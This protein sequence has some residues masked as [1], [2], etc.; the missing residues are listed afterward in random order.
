MKN[1]PSSP[2][3]L[4]RRQF[5]GTLT[6]GAVT[7]AAA[8]RAMAQSAEPRKLGVALVGLGSYATGQLAPALKLTKNCY[9]AGV[10]TGDPQGKGKKWAAERGF[11]EKNIYTYDTMHQIADNKDIDIVYVVTPNSMHADQVII[12]AKA[13][14][15]VISEKPFTTNVPDAL[16]AMAACKA[17]KVKLSIGYR[18]HFDPTVQEY[19]RMAKAKEFGGSVKMDGEFSFVA[20]SQEW[21]QKKQY[22]GGGPLMDLG[23]Y[24]MQAS[25]MGAGGVPPVAVTAKFDPTTKPQIFQDVEEGL[26]WT[27]EFPGGEVATCAASYNASANRFRIE[28]DK[29]WLDFKGMVTG[30]DGTQREAGNAFMYTGVRA[31]TNKGPLTFPQVNQQAG[32]MDDF[33]QCIREGRES[34]VSAEMGLRDL[35]IIE[36]IYE[37]AN[38][39][40]KRVLVKA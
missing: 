15:H 37:S 8:S 33:A 12:A 27:M 23:V 20:R 25:C 22:A 6:A 4:S 28:G 18:L 11:P 5:V 3:N 1:E 38:N 19:M 2:S 30:R 29:G 16:R 34:R 17:A 35:R 40:S 9:L 26:K 36:A 32:E 14:K 24:V 39:G 13:G 10:V 7:L 21:R 31:V